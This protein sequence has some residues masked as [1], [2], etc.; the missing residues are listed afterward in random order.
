MLDT[1]TG[2]IVGKDAFDVHSSR[3]EA[4]VIFVSAHVLIEA[5]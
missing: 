2:P 4:L 1:I 5:F 3:F